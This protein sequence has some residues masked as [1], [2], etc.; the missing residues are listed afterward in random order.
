MM[1]EICETD[2]VRTLHFGSEWIQ[3][4]MRVAR[5]WHLELEY[6]REMMLPLMLRDEPEEPLE[7]LLIGLGAASMIRYLYRHWPHT[8]LTVVEISAAVVAAAR[9]S[10]KLPEDPARIDLQVADGVAYLAQC[11]QRFD[12]IL[13]DGFDARARAGGLQGHP[14]YRDCRRCLA[15]NGMLAVNLLSRQSHY[16]RSIEA[17]GR[18]FDG[19]SLAFPSMDSGNVVA[20]ASSTEGAGRVR[21]VE[22]RERALLWK[23]TRGI[24]L[25]PTVSRLEQSRLCP[26]GWLEL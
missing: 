16:K 21:L 24:D 22:L 20:L 7:I 15:Q 14:F 12:L 10:F 11:T 4:A 19:R 18:V 13:V 5:P 9:Q 6:T 2:G 17:L 8:R 3:G 26:H 1:I 23:K 25:R